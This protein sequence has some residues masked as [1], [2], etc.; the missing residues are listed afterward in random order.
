MRN[1]FSSSYSGVIVIFIVVYRLF[2]QI[3]LVHTPS[4]LIMQYI[5]MFSAK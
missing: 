5:Y 3:D 2:K 1:I 4:I